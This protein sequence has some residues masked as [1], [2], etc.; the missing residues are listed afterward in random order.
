MFAAEH[1]SNDEIIYR[2]IEPYN[3]FSYIKDAVDD[4][5]EKVLENGGDV[6]FVD[7]GLLKKH[8]HIA[9]ILFY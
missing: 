1:G 6:E 5:I 9:L 7:E 2:A 3:K 8:K 4:V